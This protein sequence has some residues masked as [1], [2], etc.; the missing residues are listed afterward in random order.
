MTY[1]FRVSLHEEEDGCWSAWIDSLPGRADW[2]YTKD[3][4]L[5]ELRK[6]AEMFV[7]SMLEHSDA[8]PND[9]IGSTADVGEGIVEVAI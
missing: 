2:G 1:T 6:A 4:A 5:E 3:E 9:D 7:A 8:I